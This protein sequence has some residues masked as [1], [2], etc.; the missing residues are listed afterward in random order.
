MHGVVIESEKKARR[1]MDFSGI[2]FSGSILSVPKPVNTDAKEKTVNLDGR[3]ISLKRKVADRVVDD[4]FKN[5]DGLVD[6]NG[7]Y[8]K[9]E[10]SAKKQGENLPQKCISKPTSRLWAEKWRPRGFLDV[11]GN[12]RASKEVLKWVAQWT[13]T[14][15]PTEDVLNRPSKRILLIHGPPGIGKTTVAHAAARQAGFDVLEINA[16]DERNGKSLKDKITLSLTSQSFSGKPV[17][18]VADEIDGSLENGAVKILLDLIADDAKET[19]HYV[20]RQKNKMRLLRRPIIAVC[21]DLYAPSLERLRPVSEV[22]AFR[23]I[24]EPLIKQRLMKICAKEN[25]ALSP[26]SLQEVIALTNHDLRNCLNF[27]QLN[28]GLGEPSGSQQKDTPLSWWSMRK[29][30]FKRNVAINKFSQCRS[31]SEKLNACS[32]MDRLIL[33]CYN[34]IHDVEYQDDMMSKPLNLADWLNF[35]DQVSSSRH[36]SDAHGYGSELVLKLFWDFGDPHNNIM[37][38]TNP[39][40]V[41]YLMLYFTLTNS[42]TRKGKSTDMFLKVCSLELLIARTTISRSYRCMCFLS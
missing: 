25:L 27:L 34:S 20:K 42:F 21:N 5:W 14:S 19:E 15:K 12:E 33:G 32:S 2:S 4:V 41:S 37:T 23:T 11:V 31:L 7:L 35:Y 16:S 28:K 24:P 3:S 36:F 26:S 30:V 9:L 38:S 18:L 10:E 1:V 17:C 39:V 6:M 29:S 40:E 22:I 13:R 8:I